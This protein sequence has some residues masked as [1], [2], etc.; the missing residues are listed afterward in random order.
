MMIIDEIKKELDNSVSSFKVRGE[1]S[2]A[3][4]A[5]VSITDNTGNPIWIGT[6]L[7]NAKFRAQSL[8]SG[9]IITEGT[10]RIDNSHMGELHQHINNKIC[11]V[12][13]EVKTLSS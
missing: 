5:E 11:P 6:P 3:L 4:W 13:S 10:Y 7:D 1:I 8:S 2:G 9:A 12:S